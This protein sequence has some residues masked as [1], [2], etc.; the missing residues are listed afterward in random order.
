MTVK[1]FWVGKILPF[2]EFEKLNYYR[3][4]TKINSW[5]EKQEKEMREVTNLFIK[6]YTS[7]DKEFFEV[8]GDLSHRKEYFEIAKILHYLDERL[9]NRGALK[10]DLKGSQ[11]HAD[12]SK[13][14]AKSYKY[15]YIGLLYIFKRDSS[16]WVLKELCRKRFFPDQQKEDTFYLNEISIIQIQKQA[17]SD[18]MNLEVYELTDKKEK[19]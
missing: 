5:D 8:E 14:K 18:C 15:S 2:K 3:S 19:R 7:F 6:W 10:R 13:S 4:T 9:K 12:T 17:T 11:F 1:Q 16:K